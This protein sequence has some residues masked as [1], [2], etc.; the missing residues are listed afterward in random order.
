MKVK[1]TPLEKWGKV[2]TPVP[3]KTKEYYVSTMGRLKSVDK[4]TGDERLLNPGLAHK[5]VAMS[6]RLSDNSNYG[7]FVGRWVA[8]HFVKN[9]KNYT[10]L[11]HLDHDHQ[12]N[13]KTN[14]KW[15]SPSEAAQH[16]LKGEKERNYT[17]KKPKHVRMT[18]AKVALLKK[19]L[20]I[21]RTKRKILAKQFKITETQI[22]RI[23]RG[24]NWGHVEPAK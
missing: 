15:V 3:T 5:V 1:S 24:E 7:I 8:T 20:R 22:K 17:R 10:N 23:E 21:G 14:L 19:R 6:I 11:I 13:R 16:V 12:N 18:E 9:P 2:E 4:K